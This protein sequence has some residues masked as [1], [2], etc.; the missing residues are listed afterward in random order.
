VNDDQP[1]PSNPGHLS[2][3]TDGLDARIGKLEHR[4]DELLVDRRSSN[5][6]GPP[7]VVWQNLSR[8]NKTEE[9]EKL[10]KWVD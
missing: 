9:L 6:A 2:D 5:D 1:L 10:A 8:A 4:F 7:V 3:K